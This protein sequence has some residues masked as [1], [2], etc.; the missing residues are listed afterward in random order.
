ME[1]KVYTNNSA[2][3]LGLLALTV[4]LVRTEY[5]FGQH[6]LGEFKISYG[7]NYDQ[8]SRAS[9]TS[10]DK[11]SGPGSFQVWLSSRFAMHVSSSTF[12]SAGYSTKARQTGV[13]DVAI[14]GLFQMF[15][16]DIQG[17]R[18]ALSLDYTAKIPTADK[19]VGGSGELDHQVKGSLSKAF[20]TRSSAQLD[21]GIYL[22]GK[23]VGGYAPRAIVAAAVQVGLGH[24][25]N[26]RFVWTLS[27]EFN[28]ASSY[29]L[30]PADLYHNI[31]L[32]RKLPGGFALRSGVKVG[33]TPYTARFGLFASISYSGHL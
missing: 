25:P 19:A 18:P 1:G 24:P 13:G 2:I 8:Q 17:I 15:N 28:S 9:T 11:E 4:T 33:L 31:A 21:S 30:G 23:S 5:A 32:Q 29:Q 16:E 6:T 26:D 22:T 7:I 12:K 14:G 10:S 20:S 27:N 3:R